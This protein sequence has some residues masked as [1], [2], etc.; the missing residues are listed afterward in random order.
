MYSGNYRNALE[1]SEAK[2]NNKF[3][4]QRCRHYT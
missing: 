4:C 2:S 1:L 3:Q